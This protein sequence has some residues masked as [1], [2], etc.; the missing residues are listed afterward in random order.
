MAIMKNTLLIASAL[1]AVI[2]STPASAITVDANLADWGVTSA[3][4]TP[5]AGIKYTIEDQTSGA[6]YLDPGWGGQA[7]DAE[8]LYTTI[9]DNKLYVALVTGHDPRTLNNPAGNSYGAGDFAFDFG[10]NGSYE[11]GINFNHS[12]AYNSSTNTYTYENTFAQGGFYQN[13]TW[14]LGLWSR[15][16][17]QATT[18]RPADPAHPTSLRTGTYTG[19]AEL[20]YTTTAVNGHYFYE[21]SLDL[22]LLRTA[23]WDGTSTFGIHWTENC[24]NDAIWVEST[25]V[26]E[27]GSLALI[28]ISLLGL[29][30][31]RRRA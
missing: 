5:A 4:W 11:A 14:N 16:G 10:K 18:T 8:A 17:E 22:G 13:A 15:S 20:A 1:T 21:M 26:P 27:P 7:Y 12:T 30:G 31:S 29:F 25:A 9:R 24:A 28:G 3:P 6:F 23:G 2:A 19:Q